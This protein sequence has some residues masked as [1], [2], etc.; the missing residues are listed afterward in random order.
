MALYCEDGP[1]VHWNWFAVASYAASVAF[2][3]A[4]WAGLIRGVAY[5]M[6]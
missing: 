5:L 4:F 3:V 1:L 2:S 6:R